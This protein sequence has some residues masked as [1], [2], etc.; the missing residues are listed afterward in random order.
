LRRRPTRTTTIPSPAAARTTRAQFP[1][2]DGVEVFSSRVALAA[3]SLAGAAGSST[4]GGGGA[5]GSALVAAPAD[6]T[7]AAAAEDD[8]VEPAAGGGAEEEEEGGAATG[9]LALAIG[10]LVDRGVGFEGADVT[11][12]VVAGVVT[13][14]AI[15]VRR[16]GVAWT[17]GV[18]GSEPGGG[19]TCGA[20]VTSGGGTD[21]GV[22][23]ESW[24]SATPAARTKAKDE[25]RIPLRNLM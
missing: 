8:D 5:G 15:G 11:S 24:A 9:A 18:A 14:V 20:A 19:G 7:P 13:G 4:N 21:P 6:S 10:V 22:G 16:F 2:S 25:T 17:S 23:S 3:V 1:S 12:G